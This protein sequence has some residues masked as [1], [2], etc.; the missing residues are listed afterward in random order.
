M[1]VRDPGRE[2]VGV[3]RYGA[4]MSADVGGSGE[5]SIKAAIEM[6]C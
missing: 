6:V 3:S 5:H 1:V 4:W 2:V